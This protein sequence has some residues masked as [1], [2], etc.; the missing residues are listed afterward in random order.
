MLS[1]MNF[2]LGCHPGSNTASFASEIGAKSM[3]TAYGFNRANWSYIPS[4]I[5]SGTALIRPDFP[6]LLNWPFLWQQVNMF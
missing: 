1:A 2:V 3:T 5:T 4:G 6:G